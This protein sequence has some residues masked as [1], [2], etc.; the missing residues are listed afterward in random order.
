M[1]NSKKKYICTHV[2]ML[3]IFIIIQELATKTFKPL[4]RENKSFL[5]SKSGGRNVLLRSNLDKSIIVAK[6][7]SYICVMSN[8]K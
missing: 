3:I 4:A 7:T 1:L 8:M 5:I 6:Y 2:Y